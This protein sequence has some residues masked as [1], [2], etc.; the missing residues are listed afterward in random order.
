MKS[1]TGRP[2][3]TVTASEIASWVY[4]P[5]AWRLLSIGHESANQDA[6]DV[7]T[8]HHQKTAAAEVVAGRSIAVGRV[9]IFAALMG[10]A[11]LWWLT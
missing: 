5:E 3:A 11:L 2:P 4:C 10:L 8:A 1:E 7:G 9:L 6:R